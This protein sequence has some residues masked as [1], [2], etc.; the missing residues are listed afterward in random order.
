MAVEKWSR[1]NVVDTQ[2]PRDYRW[3]KK[4]TYMTLKRGA[5]DQRRRGKLLFWERPP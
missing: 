5:E 3:I 2:I 1:V 4:Y